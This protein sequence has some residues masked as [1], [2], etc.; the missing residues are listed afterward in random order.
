MGAGASSWCFEL[1]CFV[2]QVS[3]RT[4][5]LHPNIYVETISEGE[6]GTLAGRSQQ[7]RE[8]QQAELCE[9]GKR[10]GL[11]KREPPSCCASLSVKGRS[12][13]GGH[14]LK[15]GSLDFPSEKG[16]SGSKVP[17]MLGSV[18]QLLYPSFNF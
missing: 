4:L 2:I 8:A 3:D 14:M 9:E 11:Q 1:R 6:D 17:C 5:N 7:S 18:W 13:R 12:D 16:P 15:V 10:I